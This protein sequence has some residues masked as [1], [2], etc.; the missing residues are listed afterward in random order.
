MNVQS[1]KK[2]NLLLKSLIESDFLL[3][4]QNSS[5]SPRSVGAIKRTKADSLSFLDPVESTK[6]VKQLIRLLQFLKKQK[7]NF[8]TC[9]CK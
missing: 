8:F 1:K 7:S 4:S 3:L 9:C 6:T 5:N 2:Q